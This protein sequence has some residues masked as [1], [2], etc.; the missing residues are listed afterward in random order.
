MMFTLLGLATLASAGE[1]TNKYSDTWS[2]QYGENFKVVKTGGL[3]DNG[4]AHFVLSHEGE[5]LPSEE[6]MISAG[7]IELQEGDVATQYV[8]T[9]VSRIAI[10]STTH[11]T[12]LEMLE[13]RAAIK[14]L[15]MSSYYVSSPCLQSLVTSGDVIETGWTAPHNM[16]QSEVDVTFHGSWWG[17]GEG[18]GVEVGVWDHEETNLLGVG[19]I[20][21]LFSVFFDKEDLANELFDLTE[22][23]LN[24]VS[25]NGEIF[26]A[27]HEDDDDVKVLYAH[28]YVY[29]CDWAQPITAEGNECGGWSIPECGN[30]HEQA[31]NISGSVFLCDQAAG[32]YLSDEDFVTW[33]KDADVWVYSSGSDWDSVYEDNKGILETFQSVINQRVYDTSKAGVNDWFESR[34]ASPDVLVEDFSTIITKE[35]QFSYETTYLRDVF[36]ESVGDVG[37]CADTTSPYVFVVGECERIETE[38]ELPT[39]DTASQQGLSCLMLLSAALA[40]MN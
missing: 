24:C 12:F 7:L 11:I 32:V 15:A 40:M 33:G 19:E 14:V 10:D 9:P 18:T 27:N 37:E 39:A 30:Y 3:G 4:Y 2:V 28:K 17:G 5:V 34:P 20:I 38:E 36:T 22:E 21:K 6:D 25:H 1:V 8:T 13:E 29:Q 23:R 35:S 26:G 31:A 16:S